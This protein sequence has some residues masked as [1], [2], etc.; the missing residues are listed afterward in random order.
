MKAIEQYFRIVLFILLYRLILSFM[1][2]D[3]TI[4]RDH[5][6]ESY[7]AVLLGGTD[8]LHFFISTD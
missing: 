2:L 7:W 6:N 3:G 5:L 1:S 4:I 8:S